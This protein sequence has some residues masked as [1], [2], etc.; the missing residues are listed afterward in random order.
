MYWLWKSD[1]SFLDQCSL[2]LNTTLIPLVSTREDVIH[3]DIPWTDM[4][5][6]VKPVIIILDSKR[7]KL[8]HCRPGQALRVPGG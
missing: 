2:P 4:F 5:G 8:S 6:P 7:V 1:S 3:L